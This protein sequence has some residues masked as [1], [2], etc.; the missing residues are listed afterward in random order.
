MK[1]VVRFVILFAAPM[2]AYADF[3]PVP[4]PETL[5]L[6]GIGAVGLLVTMMRRK[7]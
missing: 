5:S 6:F 2:A 3:V 1:T 4:E 7:K